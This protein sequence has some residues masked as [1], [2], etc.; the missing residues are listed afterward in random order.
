MVP[1][2]LRLIETANL[3]IQEASLT[4]E[5][6]PVEKDAAAV[7][8]PDRALG[9]RINLGRAVSDGP[10]PTG[11][12]DGI[13]LFQQRALIPVQTDLL[14]LLVRSEANDMCEGQSGG[15]LVK[16]ILVNAREIDATSAL[17]LERRLGLKTQAVI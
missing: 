1:A 8:N 6:V 10:I 15:P 7:L 5:S 13:N 4:G 17:E 11:L 14:N 2:D 3:K 12:A 16:Q 9:D